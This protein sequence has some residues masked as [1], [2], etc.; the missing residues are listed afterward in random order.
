MLQAD[1]LQTEVTGD[2]DREAAGAH[3]PEAEQP[4]Y[5]A[6]LVP[7]QAVQVTQEVELL[8]P[9]H[10]AGAQ[11]AVAEVDGQFLD[12]QFP[13]HHELQGN[14]VADGLQLLQVGQRAAIGRE[15][16][17]HGIGATDQGKRQRGCQ[18]GIQQA[19]G[20]PGP[21]DETARR[22]AAA[23]DHVAIGVEG[24]QQI[25][26]ALRRMGQIG[27]HH[28]QPVESAEPDSL[29]NGKGQVAR[30]LAARHQ[31]HG[32]APRQLRDHGLAAVIRVVVDQQQLPGD[33]A[34][35]E[36][37]VNP[38]GQAGDVGRLAKGRHDDGNFLG[39][40]GT[41]EVIR[42]AKPVDHLGSRSL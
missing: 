3:Q 4:G 9:V 30:P 13:A 39:E 28:H 18:A 16:P 29:D 33:S 14:L 5:P 19:P 10:L 15:K 38:L 11:A 42:H 25:G 26:D 35:G 31:A 37:G 1:P 7:V 12:T 23:D 32:Q 36:G 20:T 40:N 2:V 21:I 22:V 41:L 6:E 27:I 34:V 8:S 24:G 17:G